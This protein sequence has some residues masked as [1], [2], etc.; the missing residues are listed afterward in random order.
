M[1]L[2]RNSICRL[3]LLGKGENLKKVCLVK[4]YN[5]SS[6]FPTIPSFLYTMKRSS[7]QEDD[8]AESPRKKIKKDK[9]SD[10]AKTDEKHSGPDVMKI[11]KIVLKKKEKISE[12]VTKIKFKNDNK[13][14]KASSVVKAD[15][16]LSGPEAMNVDEIVIKKEEKT[17]EHRTIIKFKKDNKKDKAS[18][19]AK[20]DKKHSGTVV[21]EINKIVM[22]KKEK[23]VESVTEIK[24]KNDD[25]K[26]KTPSIAIAAQQDNDSNV[27]DFIMDI[28]KRREEA[29]ESVAQFKFNK[30]RA[31]VLSE[32]EEFPE[33]SNGVL[34]WMSRDQRTQDNWAFLY[35][36]R[37]ALKLKVPLYVC[38]CLR[39][40]FL[41]ATIRQFGFMMKGL[42]IV[43][44]EC[45]DL[46]ISFYLL[47]GEASHCIPPF[48]KSHNIGGV[49]TDFAPLRTPMKWV[50]NLKKNLPK[51]IPFCQVD[52]HNIVPCWVASPKLEYGA[53]TIRS[54]IHKQLDEFLTEFPP[55]VKH[56][57]P[58]EKM[59]EET[60][61]EK[62]D[63]YLEVNRKVA[64]VSWA[65]PGAES[66]LRMLESFCEKRLKY[67]SSDRND[68]NKQALSNLSP[69]F[70]FGQ[71]SV[72]RCIL[73]VKLYRSKSNDSVNAFIEEA[74]VR[75]ELADNFCFYNPHY[76]SVQG[77]NDWAKKSLEL[78]RKDKR[79]YLYSR[80]QLE[81]SKTHD[82]LWNA[83]QTQL[84]NEGKMHGFL[85]MYW[86]K[87]I[88]EWTKS[89]EDALADAIYLNDKYNLDGRDP[90][91]YVGCM[92]SICGIHDQGWAER[93]VFGKIRYMNYQ[94]CSLQTAPYTTNLKNLTT[95]GSKVT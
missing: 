13:K 64:E 32:S 25:K 43:E 41:E 78:H 62:A 79:P 3:Y 42:A 7:A 12:S 23:V 90:N 10:V 22:K 18:G 60:D 84:V 76:D 88:L 16:E 55:L 58:P 40:Q 47:L 26:G 83:A 56:P 77:T 30:K 45:R 49:V 72:Q 50:E 61:W 73:T 38:F 54:K 6:N 86:A 57:H 5:Q 34:Y 46:D 80:D 52:A 20:T 67:F 1:N 81:Q 53:R 92:W 9:T 35:A 74:V 48:L 17:L 4:L 14:G 2:L 36:Q 31:R 85:R 95:Q 63:S 44:K 19:V 8:E 71:I 11:D 59:P 33:D 24:C 29:W 21:K 75:R 93:A 82:D 15:E 66:G 94:G 87:K 37:L 51:E 39:P 68:P 27:A 69:W 91:G 28:V 65:K 89:P 70:H